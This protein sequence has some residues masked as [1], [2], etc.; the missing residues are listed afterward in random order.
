MTQLTRIEKETVITFNELE[1]T[2]HVYTCNSRMK[3]KLGKLHAERP[4]DV[5]LLST[6]SASSTYTV[7]K[8]WIKINAAR[9]L[10][11]EQKQKRAE[12]LARARERAMLV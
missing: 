2:A 12:T 7:P 9:I 6:D 11:D 1:P 10:T 4:A 8:A 3:G 5:I